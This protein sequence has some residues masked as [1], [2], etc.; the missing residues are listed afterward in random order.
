M[1]YGEL[2]VVTPVRDVAGVL[3]ETVLAALDECLLGALG[4]QGE[5]GGLISE[6]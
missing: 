5:E 4:E 6:D 3:T 2:E 1:L